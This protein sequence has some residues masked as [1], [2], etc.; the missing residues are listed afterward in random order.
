MFLSLINWVT[1]DKIVNS[2]NNH[3]LSGMLVVCRAPC[4][5]LKDLML[6]RGTWS[7]G[8][9][10][11]VT[12]HRAEACQPVCKDREWLSGGGAKSLL[13][14]T[15]S[16]VNQVPVPQRVSAE[17]LIKQ[18]RSKCLPQ[19]LLNECWFLSTVPGQGQCLTGAWK[20]SAQSYE[21]VSVVRQME[22]TDKSQERGG[23]EANRAWS[24]KKVPGSVLVSPMDQLS[25]RCLSSTHHTLF[26]WKIWGVGRHLLSHSE[27]CTT[28][29]WLRI[30]SH[31]DCPVTGS[32]TVAY[33]SKTVL[34]YL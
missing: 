1:F 25:P 28:R 23:S 14:S 18:D 34:H 11:R 6:W 26:A 17:Y 8:Q 5:A 32:C 12:G 15:S 10:R 16:F 20:A 27:E 31:F 19:S 7:R 21:K 24:W 30:A 33:L 9:L 4:W 22:R 13:V 3:L 29:N 2:C